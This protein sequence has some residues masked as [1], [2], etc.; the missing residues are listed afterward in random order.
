MFLF[1][2]VRPIDSHIN[3]SDILQWPFYF[4]RLEKK[5]KRLVE[6]FA[7]ASYSLNVFPK[8]TE[9]EVADGILE[10]YTDIHKRVRVKYY[11]KC[12]GPA[13]TIHP[14][15]VLITSLSLKHFFPCFENKNLV[16]KQLISRRP[17]W[18][19]NLF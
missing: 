17:H 4:F 10:A 16:F 3:L 6:D 8:T 19:E 1:I 5:K 14:D 7:S 9:P 15:S 12:W 18:I 11:K 2:K 13:G